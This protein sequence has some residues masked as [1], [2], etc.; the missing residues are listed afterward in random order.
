LD[1]GIVSVNTLG[2]YAWIDG[3]RNG[4]QDPGEQPAPQVPVNL[5]DSTGKTIQSTLTGTDGKYSFTNLPDG[6]Y[7]VCFGPLSALAAKYPG[8]AFTQQN[9]GANPTL[10]SSANPSTGCTQPVTLGPAKRLDLTLDA[11]LLPPQQSGSGGSGGLAFTGVPI[12]GLG[13]LGAALLIAGGAA[14]AVGRRRRQ[15]H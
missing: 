15:Q 12:L 11:G 3:N 13:A 9:A 2:D 5:V 14:I 6:T 4:I 8:Y 7:S 10:A 1:V